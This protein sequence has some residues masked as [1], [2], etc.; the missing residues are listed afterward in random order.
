MDGFVKVVAITSTELV[1]RAAEI[2]GTTPNATAALGRALT[3]AS[4]MGNM[5]KVEKGS[6]TCPNCGELLEF[7]VEED[8]EEDDEE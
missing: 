2:H 3:A 7:S 8:E 5:Q 6:M 4:M 1:R